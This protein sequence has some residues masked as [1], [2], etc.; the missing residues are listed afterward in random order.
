MNAICGLNLRNISQLDE[1]KL[2]N[3]G[4]ITEQF[5]G[6]HLQASLTETPK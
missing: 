1:M 5:I 6:Q 4:A 2:I 3:E